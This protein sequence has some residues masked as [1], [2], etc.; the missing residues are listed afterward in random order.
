MS[1]QIVDA[2]VAQWPVPLERLALIGHSMGGLLIRSACHYAKGA[3]RGW[4][5]HL[6]KVVFL[7]TPHRGAPPERCGACLAHNPAFPKSRLAIADEMHHL[8]LLGRPEIHRKI[9]RWLV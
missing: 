5:R 1:A 4:L 2:L 6:R 9:R 3:Q 7:G 8:D